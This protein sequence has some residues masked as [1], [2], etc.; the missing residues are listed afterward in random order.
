MS[1][2]QMMA[3][4]VMNA[5]S[6]M[7]TGTAVTPV[8]PTVCPDPVVCPSPVSGMYYELQYHLLCLQ[9]VL[10]QSHVYPQYQVCIINCSI[11][12][13]I[14]IMSAVCPSPVTCSSPVSGMYNELQYHLLCR[15]F[16][17][18]QSCVG[19]QYHLVRDFPFRTFLGVLY[20]CDF[21]FL[22][23][24]STVEALNVSILPTD[25]KCCLHSKMI[26]KRDIQTRRKTDKHHGIKLYHLR[27]KRNGHNHICIG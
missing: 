25:Y 11:I 20:F 27:S 17:L 9:Y 5:M 21:Q 24:F 8:M 3:M 2:G 7:M 19:P 26:I 12:Y 10:A 18:V 6:S 22:Y 16:F 14:Y 4:N 13:Y 1:V 23:E 15:Q